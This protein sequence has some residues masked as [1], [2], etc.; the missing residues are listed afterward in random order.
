MASDSWL[1]LRGEDPRH[2]LP[3]AL[4]GRDALAGR[5]CGWVEQMTPFVR[6]HA[7]ADGWI[8]DPFC[9]FGTT[10]VAAALEGRTAAGVELDPRRAALARERLA[11]AGVAGC[12]VLEGSVADPAVREALVA[13]ARRFALC[14]T[15]LPYFGAPAAPGEGQLYGAAAYEPF[16]QGLRDVFAGVHALLEPGGWCIAMAQNLRLGGRFVPLAWDVA[17]LLGERFELHEERVLV[18]DR[19]SDGDPAHTNRAH[20]YALVCRKPAGALDLE[21]AHALLAALTAA[22]FEAA[23]CGSFA[24]LL[25][26][27]AGARPNDLDVVVAADDGEVARLLQWL[28]A[29]GFRVESWNAPVAPPVPAAALGYRHYFR[30]RRLDREGRA[31]QLDVNVRGS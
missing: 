25:Q 1:H 27:D 13:G 15:N 9:G 18:Y 29:L 8:V 30:A 23:P 24:R 2:A 3:A 7:R 20:E 14:L 21:A 31:L 26:G 12:P 5:D 28:E 10:L 17:R 22:G 11:Q 4:R 16:L 19:P 6:S